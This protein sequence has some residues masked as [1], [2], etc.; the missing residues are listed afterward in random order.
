MSG[1]ALLFSGQGSQ[2]VGMGREL[3]DAFPEARAV[4]DEANEAL[5]HDLTRI[6][7]EG[8]EEI[9]VL[10][11]HA[12]PAILAHSIAA[13]E[14]ARA[15][16]GSVAMVAGHSLGEFSAH[17][18]AGTLAFSD[19]IRA[20]ELRGRLMYE[21]GV[22]RGGTMAAIL[23]MDDVEVEAL[24]VDSTDE[25]SVVV[26]ANFNAPGQVVISGDV[27]AVERARDLAPGRGAKKLV[28]LSVSGAFH[29]P[30]MQPAVPGLAAGLEGMDF[31]T[32][33]RPVYSNVTAAPVTD[34]DVAR[35]LLV[36]QLTSPVRWSAS[37]AAMLEAGADRFLEL[38]PGSVL[39]GLNRRNAKG[40]PSAAISAPADLTALD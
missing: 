13:L 18:G 11:K 15:R 24:C 23:G 5:G 33:A 25:N 32:P 3:A 10:T 26:P 12:Q 36:R 9:L 29:S 16:L 8:P 28:P 31:R 37:I 30:L 19:A 34:P 2:Q 4:F 40:V 22:A 27:V 6:M 38:G 35:Q 17:V 39:T 21:A 14:V 7:W 20:V 1:L